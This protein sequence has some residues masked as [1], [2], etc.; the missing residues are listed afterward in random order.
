[1]LKLFEAALAVFSDRGFDGATTKLVAQQAGVTES[2]IMKYFGS[3]RG[4]LLALFEDYSCK[5]A[6][7]EKVPYP[8]GKNLEGEFASFITSQL[9]Q[10]LMTKEFTRVI[11]GNASVDEKMRLELS[12]KVPLDWHPVLKARLKRY[13]EKGEIPRAVQIDDIVFTLGFQTFATMYV[14]NMLLEMPEAEV[15][16]R[17]L[18]YSRI[19]ASG[20]RATA[21][22]ESARKRR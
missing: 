9:E 5:R 7:G 10:C 8:E 13:R 20:L 4:L 19:Y 1:M 21:A 6:Q 22:A 11:L 3:K 17:I 16:R 15:R 14:G 18:L 2:L 12:K